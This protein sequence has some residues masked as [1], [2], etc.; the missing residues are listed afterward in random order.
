MDILIRTSNR[1][2]R[3]LLGCLALSAL[4]ACGAKAD[5]DTVTEPPPAAESSDGSHGSTDYKVIAV[6]SASAVGGQVSRKPVPLN[7]DR[8]IDD[9]VGQFTSKSFASKVR[10]LAAGHESANGMALVGTVVLGCEN[11][12]DVRVSVKAGQVAIAAPEPTGSPRECL[13][14][15]TTVALVEVDEKLVG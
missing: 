7:S 13:V 2:R 11:L 5:S 3:V 10:R 1:P 8:A 6:R 14:A 9:F 12:T 15:V 4:T